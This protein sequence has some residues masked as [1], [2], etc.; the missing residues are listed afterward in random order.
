MAVYFALN[1]VPLDEIVKY[2]RV[3]PVRVLRNEIIVKI[4]KVSK[5]PGLRGSH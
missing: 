5:R 2:S 1:A 3:D 4:I